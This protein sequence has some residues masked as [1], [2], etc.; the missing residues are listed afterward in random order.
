MCSVDISIIAI[1]K[2]GTFLKKWT[3]GAVQVT[4]P[5]VDSSQ[6]VRVERARLRPANE[7]LELWEMAFVAN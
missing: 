7:T 6:K 5:G 2:L 3:P 4:D 1:A